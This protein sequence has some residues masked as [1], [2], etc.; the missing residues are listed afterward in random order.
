MLSLFPSFVRYTMLNSWVQV[1]DFKIYGQGV[2]PRSRALC[3]GLSALVNP[4][5]TVR[6]SFC[7]KH[8]QEIVQ[9]KCGYS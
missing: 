7:S 2:V 9:E 6:S 4:Y 5:V 1:I 8:T 3:I